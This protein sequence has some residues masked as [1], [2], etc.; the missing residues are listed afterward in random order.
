MPPFHVI[1]AVIGWLTVLKRAQFLDTNIGISVSITFL[2]RSTHVNYAIFSGSL[3][4]TPVVAGAF[5]NAVAAYNAGEFQKA[6][7]IDGTA[8]CDVPIIEAFGIVEPDF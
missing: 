1:I 8:E 4:A 5:E 7:L 6:I 2:P 3:F